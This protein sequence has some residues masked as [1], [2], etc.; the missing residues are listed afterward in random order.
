MQGDFTKLLMEEKENVTWKSIINNVP[1]GVLSFALNS[2][3]NTLATPDNL[4]RWGKR[5]AS[6]W[7]LCSDHGTLEHILNFCSISLNQ[8][9]FT[10]RHN[11]VLSH[12]TNTIVQNKPEHL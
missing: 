4:R 12:I 7:P 3:T 8:G 2:A 6:K 1:R 11:T 10:W 9:R 5:M